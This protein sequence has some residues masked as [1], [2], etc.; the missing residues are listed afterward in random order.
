MTYR[1]DTTPIEGK[2]KELMEPIRLHKVDETKMESYWD[3]LVNKYHY[4]GYNW[5]YGG[6]VK[7]LIITGDRII[8]AISFCSAVYHLGPRD[9]YIGWDEK[10]RFSL[11]P[12]IICNNRFLLL[13]FVKVRNLAS[14]VLSISL[15]QLARDWK[16]QYEIEPFMIETFVDRGKFKGTSYQASNWVCL[17]K[18]QGYGKHGE[19]FVYHGSPKDIYVRIVNRRFASQF[20]PDIKRLD[21]ERE[22]I[23]T[24]INGVPEWVPSILDRMGLPKVVANGLEWLSE[25]LAD[26]LKR[27]V[28]FLGRKEH[29]GHLLTLIK[30]RLSDVKRKSNEPV[31]LTFNGVDGVRTLANFMRKDI[32]DDTGMLK[33][34]QREVGEILFEREGMITADGCDIPK[35]GKNSVGVQRQYCG[36]L[37]KVE[38]CQA[39]VMVGYAG[40]NGYGL[41]D[42]ELYM[43][44][45]WFNESHAALR[46]Q[47]LVPDGLEF[48]TKNQ[49]LS[50][51][52]QNIVQSEQFQGKYVGVDSSFGKD[53]DFLDSLPKNLIYFADIPNNTLVFRERPI[54]FIPAYSGK[55][56]KPTRPKTEFLP[57]HVKSFVDDDEIPWN[58]VVLGI[59]AK[60]PIVARDKI[61]R[62][63][64]VR[65][66]FSGQDVWLYIRKLEDNSIKY[67]LCNEPADSAPEII[68]KPALMR[69][70]IEQCFNECKDHLGM[71]QYEVRSWPGWRRHILITLIA[72]LF[73][74][75]LRQQFSVRPRSPGATPFVEQPVSLDDFLDAAKKLDNNEVIVHPY[76]KAFPDK[77]QQLLTIGLVLKL[78]SPFLTKVG[79]LLSEID[80]YLKNYADAFTSHSKSTLKSLR[81]S[82]EE[83]VVNTG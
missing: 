41:L 18:T 73:V 78:I 48:K 77:P 29:L 2:L 36:N 13:P 38:N 58:N 74:N 70:S 15:K 45:T 32:W 8:G 79:E 83:S 64:E 26:H 19:S 66:D 75:K 72:H 35:K 81:D 43:P 20:R 23:I 53:K 25:S 71:D 61:I 33:E 80:Y 4:L 42:Y 62:V 39:S 60:G 76:I 69:W 63:T 28:P 31:A 68:R 22:E 6:R 16:K 59:G 1:L 11:L 5:Q 34:Y 24:M 67:A 57:I 65:D 44:E 17:G 10:T 46:K 40:K 3:N 52:I 7:Y 27:Y 50:E 82:R 54:H 12:H 55:G 51:M 49:L 47:N 21:A 56:R 30:G 9:R 14:H 37:G